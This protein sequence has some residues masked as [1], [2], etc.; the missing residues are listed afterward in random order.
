MSKEMRE[1]IDKVKNFGEF[2]NEHIEQSRCV[3]IKNIKFKN[4]MNYF[5]D[6][7]Y[8]CEMN[9]D[10]VSVG[11]EDGRFTTMS[12]DIFDIHFQVI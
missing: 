11:Y 9:I 4:G 8:T 3:C 6:L 10:R 7:T 1:Q 2:L 5:K 12:K